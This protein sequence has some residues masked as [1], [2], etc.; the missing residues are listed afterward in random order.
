MQLCPN[1]SVELEE[2]P[3]KFCGCKKWMV[4]PI[5]GYREKQSESLLEAGRLIDRIKKSN[6]NE[7]KF[8][9]EEI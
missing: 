5:C 8:N 4:C 1:C 3:K 6:K 7:N 9:T 2:S